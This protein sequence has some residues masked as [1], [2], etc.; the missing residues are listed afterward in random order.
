MS[1]PVYLR[2]GTLYLHPQRVFETLAWVTGCNS[3]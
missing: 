3:N 2:I 1:F